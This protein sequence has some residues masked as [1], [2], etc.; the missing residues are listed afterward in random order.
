MNRNIVLHNL[1]ITIIILF[2]ANKCC[3]AS[4]SLLQNSIDIEI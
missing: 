1:L 4:L 3:M 2:N